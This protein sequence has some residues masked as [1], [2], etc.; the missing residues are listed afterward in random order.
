MDS[1]FRTCFHCIDVWNL[2]LK[3][4]KEVHGIYVELEVSVVGEES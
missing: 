4:I 1:S 2:N 3:N